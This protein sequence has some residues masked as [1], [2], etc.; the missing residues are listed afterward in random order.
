MTTP[1][2]GAGQTFVSSPT[3]NVTVNGSAG[4]PDQNQD[5]AEKISRQMTGQ[6]SALV[7]HE[8]RRQMRPGGLLR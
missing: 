7:A 3:I 6:A 5:L 4:T 8:L 2:I 1:A